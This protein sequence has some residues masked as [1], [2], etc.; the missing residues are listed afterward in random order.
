MSLLAAVESILF[1][2][3]KPLSVKKIAEL[4]QQPA[5]AVDAALQEL[6]TAYATRDGG[7]LLV[8][9]GTDYQFMTAPSQAALVQ[10]YLKDDATGDLTRPSLETLTIIAYRGPVTKAEVEQIRGVNCSLILRNL[11]IRGL[12]SA[13]E[14][15]KTLLPSYRVTMDFLRFLGVGSVEQLPDYEKLRADRSLLELLT[16]APVPP[17]EATAVGE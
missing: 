2:S 14:D 13:E 5:A 8:Q 9:N 11:L 12:V 10:A 1:V 17:A 6:R 16:P 4:V 7:V 3:S 15:P